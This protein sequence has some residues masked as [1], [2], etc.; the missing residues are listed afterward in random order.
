[1]SKLSNSFTAKKTSPVLLSELLESVPSQ[2]ASLATKAP[3]SLCYERPPVYS[4]NKWSGVSSLKFHNLACKDAIL[5]DSSVTGKQLHLWFAVNT[6]TG[7]RAESRKARGQEKYQLM[8]ERNVMVVECYN[9]IVNGVKSGTVAE[10]IKSALKGGKNQDAEL[11]SVAKDVVAKAKALG[12]KADS[13]VILAS[14]Y[15]LYN[16][17]QVLSYSCIDLTF[18]KENREVENIFQF[19]SKD[20]FAIQ[21][22]HLIIDRG[23]NMADYAFILPAEELTKEFVETHAISKK[24]VDQVSKGLTD[25]NV[26]K[27]FAL[28]ISKETRVGNF[29]VAPN[30]LMLQFKPSRKY[31]GKRNT[32]QYEV[33]QSDKLKSKEVEYA[34]QDDVAMGFQL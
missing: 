21:A 15:S 4:T 20:N 10:Q 7:N 9:S 13:P 25:S 27:R 22:T 14:L 29:Q 30:G 5:L 28:Q 3:L 26:I 19:E 6:D 11:S 32:A 12:I 34:S 17:V 1:M 8:H 16:N 24:V 33:E 31:N 23:L 2:T 18:G